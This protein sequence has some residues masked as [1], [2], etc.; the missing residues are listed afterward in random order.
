MV[1]AGPFSEVA[2]RERNSEPAASGRCTAV[3]CALLAPPPKQV[4]TT[5][6]HHIGAALNNEPIM[7]KQ[8][9]RLNN[10]IAIILKKQNTSTSL[11]IPNSYFSF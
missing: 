4:T 3:N 9:G 1:V 2:L 5:Q 6:P 8:V 11:R 10:F 7:Y